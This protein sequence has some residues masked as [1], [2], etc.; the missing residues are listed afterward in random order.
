[1]NEQEFMVMLEDYKASVEQ[2]LL[3]ISQRD[4]LGIQL[5]V[6]L[7]ALLSILALQNSYLSIVSLM[8]IPILATYFCSQ[9]FESYK[10]HE[11]LVYHIQ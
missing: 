3:R 10:I 1:M 6:S 7:G 4:N 2:V 8:L 5:F 11:R 9:I